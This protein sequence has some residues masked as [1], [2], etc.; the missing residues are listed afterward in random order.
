LYESL[1][2]FFFS[3]SLSG[4]VVVASLLTTHFCCFCIVVARSLGDSSAVR[5]QSNFL[6][7]DSMDSNLDFFMV[8]TSGARKTNLY[9]IIGFRNNKETSAHKVSNQHPIVHRLLSD[10]LLVSLFVLYSDRLFSV[11]THVSRPDDHINTQSLGEVQQILMSATNA[12][13]HGSASTVFSFQSRNPVDIRT[14]CHE[15]W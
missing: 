14:L 3:L 8:L 1:I 11:W 6:V 7:Y 13:C 12:C 15:C 4:P 5:T 2:V 9:K 10:S